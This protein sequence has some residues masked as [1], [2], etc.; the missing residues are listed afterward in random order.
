MHNTTTKRGVITFSYDSN[1]LFNDVCLLSAY[2]TKNIVMESA[3]ALDE[4]CVTEDEK[5][6]YNECLR[7]TMS[8]IKDAV[9]DMA[10]CCDNAFSD[11]IDGGNVIVSLRNNNAYNPNVLSLVDST[12]YDC[13]K[14]GIL[15]V[16]YSTNTHDGLFSM[17]SA[18]MGA[19]LSQL[20]QRLFQL[21]KKPVTY[22]L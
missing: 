8:V 9:M 11:G 10:A 5:D 21:R 19:S 18:K 7:Q 16:F 14:Y 2:M 1:G 13:L 20:R 17:S 12:I 15:S 6:V 22:Q 4:F 3:S